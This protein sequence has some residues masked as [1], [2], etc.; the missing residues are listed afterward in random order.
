MVERSEYSREQRIK[1]NAE[2]SLAQSKLPPRMQEYEER[3]KQEVETGAANDGL[4]QNQ[5]TFQPP[6]AKPVPDFKRLQKTFQQT[7]E[8]QKKQNH[9]S[10]TKPTPFHFHNPKSTASM[11]RHLDQDNQMINPTIKKVRARSAMAENRDLSPVGERDSRENPA[12]TAKFSAYVETRRQKMEGK[13][14]V[15]QAKFQE[16]VE[17]FFK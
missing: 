14:N 2:I 5:F 17:R 7:L 16:E 10:A 13:K 8:E 6:K 1:R 12:V 3:K 4:D 15:E 11:R 9:L